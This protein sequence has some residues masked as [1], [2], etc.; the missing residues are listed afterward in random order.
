M[1][2]M[3]SVAMEASEAASRAL[4]SRFRPPAGAPLELNYKEPGE[5]VTD[6]DIAS[7][8]AITDVLTR[9]GVP[10]DI[11]SEESSIDKGDGRYTWIID[12]LCGTLPFS[13]GLPHWGVCI[14]L[15][16]GPDLLIGVVT[17]PST[18]EVISAV[19]GRGAYLHSMPMK[20]QEPSGEFGETALALEGQGERF[21]DTRR[22]FQHAV[23]RG[24]AF[25]SA[26][27]PIAQVLLG[28]LHGVVFTGPISVHTA[29]GVVVARELGIPV[30][31]MAGDELEWDPGSAPNSLIIA[32]PRTH[33]AT[34]NALSKT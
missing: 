18:G 14:A 22:A 4:M 3:Y 21:S 1:D 6:A 12:P 15:G 10:G 8:K 19:Q 28:R 11:L 29:A 17:L 7:D 24:Y 9:Q 31:D 23:R 27:Y 5:L 34:I 16:S 2:N 33:E 26:A 20:S 13:T 32:W 25:G 30:T